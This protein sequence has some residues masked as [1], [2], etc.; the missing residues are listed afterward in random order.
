MAPRLPPS[1][2]GSL[3]SITAT[4]PLRCRGTERHTGHFDTFRRRVF[5][6]S[7]V[8]LGSMAVSRPARSPWTVGIGHAGG[9]RNGSATAGAGEH[10]RTAGKRAL[11]IDTFA[12][13]HPI[14]IVDSGRHELYD[15]RRGRSAGG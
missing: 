6:H 9:F 14:A 1:I 7:V 4:K 3:L 2:C 5:A 8:F 12:A 15:G 10:D 11:G 13:D